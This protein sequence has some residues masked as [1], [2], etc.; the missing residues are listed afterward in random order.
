[1][2]LNHNPPQKMGLKL[3]YIYYR[4]IRTNNH[5][6]IGRVLYHKLFLQKQF[7]FFE[8]HNNTHQ[9]MFIIFLQKHHKH[10]PKVSMYSL[11]THLLAKQINVGLT[12]T[13]CYLKLVISDQ[14]SRP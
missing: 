1:M 5:P 14:I 6:S 4:W 10:N 9:L 12:I 11:N 7:I 8:L 13:I 2:D 3:I